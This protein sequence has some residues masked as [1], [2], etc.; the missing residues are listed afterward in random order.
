MQA[1]KEKSLKHEQ[2]TRLELPEKEM[3]DFGYKVV[4]AVVD[5]FETQQDK[6]PVAS[7]SRAEMEKL[8]SEDV[9]EESTPAT[10]VLDFV[11]KNVMPQ[12]NIMSHPQ[13]YSF[14]PGPSNYI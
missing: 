5:H 10:E 14:V 13:S 9:P 4:D 3:K 1:Y 8:F 12:S 6:L 7:G 2:S 11:L